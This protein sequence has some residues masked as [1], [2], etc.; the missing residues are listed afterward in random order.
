MVNMVDLPVIKGGDEIDAKAE[1]L[2]A[3]PVTVCK[4]AETLDRANDIFDNDALAGLGAVGS[5][6][7]FREGMPL[8]FLEWFCRVGVFFLKALIPRINAS[9]RLRFQPNF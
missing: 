2:A 8:G 4:N 5:F 7:F 9:L 3:R 1:A 6:L